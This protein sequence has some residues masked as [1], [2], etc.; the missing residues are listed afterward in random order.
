MSGTWGSSG[1]EVIQ[2]RAGTASWLLPA[3]KRQ[4][5]NRGFYFSLGL[6]FFFSSFLFCLHFLFPMGDLLG[7]CNEI[8][9]R[10]NSLCCVRQCKEACIHH[11][12]LLPQKQPPT[13]LG[14][15]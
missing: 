3:P 14:S 9:N 4:P 6:A 1:C 7:E 13:C 8:K 15:R 12:S 2:V 5:S 11:S 10:Q